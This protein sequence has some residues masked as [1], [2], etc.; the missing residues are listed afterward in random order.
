M[1]QPRIVDLLNSKNFDNLFESRTACSALSP[2]KIIRKKL[3]LPSQ[4]AKLCI[5]SISE[6]DLYIK[7]WSFHDSNL[8]LD[9]ACNLDKLSI[10]LPL[11]GIP[12]GVKD[13]FDTEDMPTKYGSPIYENNFPKIDAVVVN[14]LKN[15]GAL[16]IGKTATTEFAFLNPSQTVNPHNFLHTPG[17]SSSGSAAAVADG[18]VPIALGSQ[19][20]G[21]VIRPS[22]Y[23]GIVGFKPTYG[24]I[25]TLG[26]K[27]LAPSMDTVGI[28]TRFINDIELILPVLLD[29]FNFNKSNRSFLKNIIYFEGPY[30]KE[31]CSDSRRLLNFASNELK[32][33]GFN[34]KYINFKDNDLILLSQA[35]R[36]IMSREAVD[37]LKI[38]YNSHKN[39][40]SESIQEFIN[41]GLQVSNIQYEEAQKLSLFW[42]I[43]FSEILNDK[44]IL[45]TFSSPGE[46]PLLE[47][48]TGSSI[49]NRSWTLLGLPCITIPFGI[50][51]ITKL[52]LGIQF[53]AN[54]HQD[55][56][57]LST[58]KTIKFFLD[59]FK[60]NFST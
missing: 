36:T 33:F 43:K 14:R 13:I 7:A 56:N 59:K 10:K 46:A 12:I 57:L 51:Q 5:S 48:G 41:L 44:N 40:L 25:S 22:A 18:M 29:K 4:L 19:T 52:P 9:K 6:R 23:C 38:E 42:R 28:H 53:V 49:F 39:L 55:L 30:V 32:K 31:A 16:I 3:I 60:S 50:N 27:R 1:N 15:A 58:V 54:L 2:Q 20:G 11:L 34:I 26:M 45:M 21:S 35:Q 37:S 8:V 24:I 47:L 17:G